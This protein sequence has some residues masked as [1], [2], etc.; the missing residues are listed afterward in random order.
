MLAARRVIAATWRSTWIA[1][2]VDGRAR[3]EL[4]DGLAVLVDRGVDDWQEL[5]EIVDRTI[6]GET[7]PQIALAL[8][9]KLRT[10]ERRLEELREASG[11]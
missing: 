2:T 4:E 9:M 5:A 1:S 11:K 3:Q 8:G 7:A 6:A 10:V